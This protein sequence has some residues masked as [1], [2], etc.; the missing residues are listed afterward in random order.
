MM[1][2]IINHKAYVCGGETLGYSTANIKNNFVEG[3]N[4]LSSSSCRLPVV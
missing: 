4:S 1:L 3:L 2:R